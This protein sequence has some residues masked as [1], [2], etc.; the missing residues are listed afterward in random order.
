[1]RDQWAPEFRYSPNAHTCLLSGQLCSIMGAPPAR[2]PASKCPASEYPRC[3]LPLADMPLFSRY[4]QRRRLSKI[5]GHIRGAVLDL[6]CGDASLMTWLRPNQSYTGVESR[7]DLVKELQESGLPGCFIAADLDV[8]DLALEPG[9]YDTIVMSAVIEHLR[10]PA[11]ILA[12]LP[13]SLADNGRLVI[14]TPT[15]LGD[16]V[17]RLGTVVGLF[18]REAEKEHQR[19]YNRET[20][21]CLLRTCGFTI[22][23]FETF[24]LGLN[25]LC[26]AARAP[27]RE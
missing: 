6:G 4:L 21:E 1:V 7:A 11:K 24:D 19:I 25:Q 26:I 9:A 14:T 2:L 15:R 17:H 5:R 10:T 27:R 20:L 16:I 18:S 8:D 3:P 23:H 12:S 22:E 13:Q